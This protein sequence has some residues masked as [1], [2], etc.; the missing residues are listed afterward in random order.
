MTNMTDAE[1]DEAVEYLQF[2]LEYMPY[3]K[4]IEERYLATVAECNFS[5][6]THF[7]NKTR[8]CSSKICFYDLKDSH[9]KTDDWG[10]FEW[11]E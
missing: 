5:Y 11:V 1:F 10:G 2:A 8:R 4:E 6:C 7:D 3:R 9:D